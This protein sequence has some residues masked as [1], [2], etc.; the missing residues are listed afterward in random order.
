[1]LLWSSCLSD[2]VRPDFLDADLRQHTRAVSVFYATPSLFD[3]LLLVTF[4]FNTAGTSNYAAEGG[5]ESDF[6]DI[7]VDSVENI[8]DYDK[9]RYE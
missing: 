1:M 2:C 4:K 6:I 8:D 5:P 9:R 7:G 3:Q